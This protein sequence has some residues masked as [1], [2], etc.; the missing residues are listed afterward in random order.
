MSLSPVH[1]LF[2]T[3]TDGHKRSIV[4]HTL[5]ILLFPD[6]HIGFKIPKSLSL[7][8]SSLDAVHELSVVLPGMPSLPVPGTPFAVPS[9]L[10]LQLPILTRLSF[11]EQ[12]RITYHRDVWDLRDVIGLVPGMR[13]AQWILGRVGAWGL[14]WMGKRLR[15]SQPQSESLITS[16]EAVV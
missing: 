11:N 9:P 12:G 4:E 5:N 13:V 3:H 16:A 2:T 10:H 1:S 8:A 7:R 6:M 15:S 14:S